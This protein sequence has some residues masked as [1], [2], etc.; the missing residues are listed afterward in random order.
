MY[1]LCCRSSHFLLVYLILLLVL[2]KFTCCDL[3]SFLF[4]FL[5][6][7]S[8]DRSCSFPLSVMQLRSKV[9]LHPT[10]PRPPLWDYT[11]RR[12]FFLLLFL[13]LMV[14]STLTVSTFFEF[15]TWGVSFLS[16]LSQTIYQN[17]YQLSI[18]HIYYHIYYL[19]YQHKLQHRSHS[20]NEQLIINV[21]E[22]TQTLD[23]FRYETRKNK[24]LQN[25]KKKYYRCIW[26]T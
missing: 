19:K 26:N 14:K 11:G 10:L 21:G 23:K 13:E 8:R 4:L 7:G 2:G 6:K 16:E 17:T 18:R 9:C 20:K 5:C 24:I 22:E 15:H 12:R 1:F 25:I 3:P